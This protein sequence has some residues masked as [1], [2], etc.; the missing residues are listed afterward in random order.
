MPPKSIKDSEETLQTILDKLAQLQTQIQQTHDVRGGGRVLGLTPEMILNCFI[1]G[2][3]PEIRRE[4]FV[5]QPTSI[6]QAIGLAKLLESKIHDSRKYYRNPS[7]HNHPPI[8]YHHH[9]PF[10]NPKQKPLH[11]PLLIKKLS[12]T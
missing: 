9:V 2:L 11:S 12:S 8:F 7:F 4:I 10:S 1:S 6:T 5:L 3:V